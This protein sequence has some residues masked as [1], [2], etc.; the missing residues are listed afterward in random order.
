MNPAGQIIIT[1]PSALLIMEP[2]GLHALTIFGT[3]RAS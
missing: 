1:C 3:M 2:D